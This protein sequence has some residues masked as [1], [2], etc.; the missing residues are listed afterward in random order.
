MNTFDKLAF[1]EVNAHKNLNQS[2]F[3]GSET[4]KNVLNLKK[5]NS[6]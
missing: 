4:K 3:V 1:F 5:E 6:L 2:G